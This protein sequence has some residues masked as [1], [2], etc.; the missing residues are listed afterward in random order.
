MLF[1]QQKLRISV[2]FT[3]IDYVSEIILNTKNEK[4]NSFCTEKISTPIMSQRQISC[5]QHVSEQ[6]KNIALSWI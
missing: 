1:Q 4:T 6:Q 5:F 3:S 2:I